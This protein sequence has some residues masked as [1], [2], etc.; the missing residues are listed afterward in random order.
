[1]SDQSDNLLFNLHRLAIGQDEDFVTESFVHL[2]RNLLINE[3]RAFINIFRKITKNSLNLTVEELDNLKIRSQV[4]T[5]EGVPDIELCSNE[6]RVFIEVKVES[7]FG[8]GQLEGYKKILNEDYR[9]PNTCLTVLTKYPVSMSQTNRVYDVAI[10]WVQISEWL[11]ELVLQDKVTSFLCDQFI[12]F[13][14]AR[15]MGMNAI[16]WELINGLNSFRSLIVMLGEVLAANNI[17]HA[18]SV[19]YDYYGYY[20][21]SQNFFIGLYYETPHLLTFVTAGTFQLNKTEDIQLG[22]IENNRWR[23]DLD[24]QSEE[25]YF[26][27]RSKVNQMECIDQFLKQSIQY[28]KTLGD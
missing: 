14:K 7:G 3:K 9:H 18:K 10:R 25:N 16:S 5:D 26:F 1:M 2:L 19:G 12:D 21:D 22:R 24:L 20:L 15:G 6:H 23:S 17:D 4:L 11:E 28:G 8:K 27:S 13:L